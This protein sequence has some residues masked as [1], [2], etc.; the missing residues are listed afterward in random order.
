M[1]KLRQYCDDYCHPCLRKLCF[2][3]LR[4]EFF[5]LKVFCGALYRQNFRGQIRNPYLYKSN[6]VTNGRTNFACEYLMRVK[7]GRRFMAVFISF[8]SLGC[9]VTGDFLI[10]VTDFVLLFMSLISLS[11]LMKN[12]DR[13]KLLSESSGLIGFRR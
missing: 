9:F 12:S 4:L 11:A 1:E 2:S 10:G 3:Y 5:S 8:A 13:I 7:S 6:L